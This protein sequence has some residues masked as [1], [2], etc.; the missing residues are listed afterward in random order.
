MN[1]QFTAMDINTAIWTLESIDSNP[2]DVISPN[3]MCH[4]IQTIEALPPLPEIAH[5]ILELNADPLADNKKLAQI[6]ELSPSLSSQVLKWASS[7]LYGFRG[8]LCSV[9]DAIT[10]VLGFNQVLNLAL[11]IAA[12]SPL[13]AP[14]EGPLGTRFFWRQALTGTLVA[15]KLNRKLPNSNRV[16]MGQ[17]Q[18]IYLLHNTGYLLLAH[19]FPAEFR[20]LT[21]LIKANPNI[22]ILQLERFALSVDHTQFGVWLMEAWNMPECLQTV[23]RHH[24]NP[25]YNG[26]Y[27][28]Q[29]KLTCLT[30]ILLSQMGIG[31]EIHDAAE[32]AVCCEHLG[33]DPAMAE[34]ILIDV[35]EQLNNIDVTVAQLINSPS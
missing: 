14:A 29:T 21:S 15:Q 30:N 34:A 17:M 9:Q 10:K 22:P 25:K 6:I 12:L 7:A 18:L 31:D 27:E 24:H 33:I 20:Y 11:G 28:S 16:E 13:R 1:T 35:S 5:R 4:R 3:D 2:M 19:F 23:V 8:K 32:I 26:E